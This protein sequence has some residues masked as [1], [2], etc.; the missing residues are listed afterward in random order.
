M[1][2]VEALFLMAVVGGVCVAGLGLWVKT[3]KAARHRRL[4]RRQPWQLEEHSDGELLVIYAVKPNES[5]LLIGAVPFAANDFN[6]RIEDV[7]SAGCEKV[8]GLN[9]GR[10]R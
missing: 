3:L 10:E 8:I 7:R 5:P 9:S 1:K 6:S 2:A 4:A